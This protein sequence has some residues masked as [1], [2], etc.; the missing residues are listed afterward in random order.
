[1]TKGELRKQIKKR[2]SLMTPQEKFEASVECSEALIQKR[3]FQEADI[4]LSYMATENELNPMYASIKTLMLKKT[5]AFPRCVPDSNRME[6]YA[7]KENLTIDEQL[8]EGSWGISEPKT[9]LPQI[10]EEDLIGKKV[11]VIVP[12]VAFNSNGARLG[13]GAGFYDA[14]LSRLRKTEGIELYTVGMC[15]S[16][17]LEDDI[18][19]E[20]HD[21]KID[22]V[23]YSSL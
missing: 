20:E 2:I 11:L 19:Q 22:S 23:I 12:G 14:Y 4:V 16:C 6:Y 7:L 10:H 18:P 17:Q 3:E 8:E 5:L 21:I 1:M 15:F 13:H 9:F